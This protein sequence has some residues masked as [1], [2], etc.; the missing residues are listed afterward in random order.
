MAKRNDKAKVRRVKDRIQPR[1]NHQVVGSVYVYQWLH[2]EISHAPEN[3]SSVVAGMASAIVDTN[4]ERDQLKESKALR[5]RQLE[6]EGRANKMHAEIFWKSWE[7]IFIELL[8]NHHGKTGPAIRALQDRIAESDT[9]PHD[10]VRG[11]DNRSNDFPS[12]KAIRE[13]YL[14]R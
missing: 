6:D 10:G 14:L 8:E 12:R 9:W 13:R 11:S 4:D 5:V 7:P 2:D 1:R 3:T